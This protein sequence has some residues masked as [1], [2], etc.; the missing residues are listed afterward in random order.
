MNLILQFV[1]GMREIYRI[2]NLC[3][4][5]R[6]HILYISRCCIPAL[7]LSA[8]N[9]VLCAMRCLENE[10]NVQEVKGGHAFA[11]QWI[12]LLKVIQPRVQYSQNILEISDCFPNVIEMV[13]CSKNMSVQRLGQLCQ[14]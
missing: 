13:N 9:I 8:T 14:R 10:Q 7:T 2:W 11:S 4:L 12:N 6:F 5:H 3:K 1:L